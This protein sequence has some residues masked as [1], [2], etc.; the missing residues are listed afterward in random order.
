MLFGCKRQP[1]PLTQKTAKAIF[2][3]RSE[4]D[5]LIASNP[6]PPGADGDTPY[7]GGNGNWWIGQTDTGV[8]AQ[9]PQGEQGEQG[10]PGQDLTSIIGEIRM[11]GGSA[12]PSGWL[13]CDGSQIARTSPLF[14]VLGE[15]FG[16][17]DGS[18]TFNLPAL[19]GRFPIGAGALGYD[20]GEQGGEQYHTLQAIELPPHDHSMHAHYSQS[21]GVPF[22]QN[23][24]IVGAHFNQG[25]GTHFGTS[26]T[27]ETGG[28]AAHNNV[29]QYT[30]VNF[31]IYEGS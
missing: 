19:A 18:T 24:F 21:S 6:G 9:G 12:P 31:I 22:G 11:F 3:A 25:T 17:G 1:A 13:L 28:N 20:L 8:T 16:P 30:A 15:T 4:I 7:I 2:Y 5:N 29:P 14:A 10:Q 23:G 27:G 26:Y